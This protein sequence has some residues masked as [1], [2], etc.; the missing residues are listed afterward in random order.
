MLKE[1]E[2]KL[3]ENC[4]EQYREKLIMEFL[5]E[6]KGNEIGNDASKYIYID[7]L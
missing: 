5:K 3:E 7:K 2:L 6:E 4:R 1:M